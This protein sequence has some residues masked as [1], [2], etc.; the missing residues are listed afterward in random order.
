M[1]MGVIL[2]R[3]CEQAEHAG[4]MQRHA[5]HLYLEAARLDDDGWHD[6]ARKRRNEAKTAEEQSARAR[7]DVAAL[8]KQAIDR[9]LRFAGPQPVNVV[10]MRTGDHDRHE[11]KEA[12]E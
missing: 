12:A 5:N 10:D 6:Q 9:Y 2:D 3:M 8:R 4:R 1:S 11:Y 7:N